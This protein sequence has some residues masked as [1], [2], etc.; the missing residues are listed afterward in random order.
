MPGG[1]RSVIASPWSFLQMESN[2]QMIVPIFKDFHKHIIGKGGVNVKKIRDE[3]QTRIDLPSGES[4]EEKITVTGKKANVEKAVEQLT[5]IQNE[6]VFF[7]VLQLT[8]RF[9]LSI[10]GITVIP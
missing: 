6:L 10:P 5:K 1:M 7:F 4:G 8:V 2:Y 3:T 9:S